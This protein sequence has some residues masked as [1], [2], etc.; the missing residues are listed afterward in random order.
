MNYDLLK[1]I[2]FLDLETA[3]QQPD[4]NNLN[5]RFQLLWKKKAAVLRKDSPPEDVYIE[6]AAIHAEFGK[7]ICIG[8]GLFTEENG[9]LC[10][11][12]RSLMHPEEKE[13]L[14]EFA[15]LLE[16]LGKKGWKLCAHNGKEFDFPYLC[17]RMLINQIPL[18]SQLQVMGR[19]PW[20]IQHLMDTMEMW[21]FGD[22]KAFTSLDLMAA[23]LNVPGSKDDIDGSQV[24]AVYHLEKDLSRIAR[25][26]QKDVATMALVYMR[27]LGLEILPEKQIYHEVALNQMSPN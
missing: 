5:E 10:F 8:I 26:C 4:Y 18:P 16:K 22:Y 13:I 12:T 23:C 9:V 20:E 19:R 15:A 3:S 6:K 14:S 11:K 24:G 25:Y 21:K 27:L 2:L 7:I 17:R 1:N